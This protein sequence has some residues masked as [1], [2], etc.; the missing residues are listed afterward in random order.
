MRIRVHA[1]LTLALR[2]SVVLGSALLSDSWRIRVSLRGNN[3]KSP[4]ILFSPICFPRATSTALRKRRVASDRNRTL[5][6]ACKHFSYDICINICI[7]GLPSVLA[8][9]I[10]PG[11]VHLYN[12][13]LLARVQPPRMQ[14]GRRIS[15]HNRTFIGIFALLAN[16]NAGEPEI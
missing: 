12:S 16:A 7:R 8:S 11:S 14:T 3:N 10:S 1:R 5:Y 13:Y 15:E 6:R 4:T 9:L 2:R